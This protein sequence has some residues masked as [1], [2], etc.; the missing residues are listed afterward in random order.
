MDEGLRIFREELPRIDL[1]VTAS[2]MMGA[3]LEAWGV[4]REKIVRIPLGVDLHRFRPPTPELRA[5]ARRRLGIPDERTCVGSFQKDGVGWGEGTEPKLIKGPDVFVSVCNRL[6]SYCP[7]FVLLTGPARGYVKAKLEASGIPYRHD[8][9][10]DPADLPRYYH[11]LDM[12]L[13]TAREEG[14]PLALPEAMAAGTPII[15]TRVGMAPDMIVTGENG[16]LV[17]VEDVDALAESARRL[18]DDPPMRERLARSALATVQDYNRF[19]LARSLCERV[20]KRWLPVQHSVAVPL[21]E[22]M[23]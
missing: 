21:E 18:V 3:R 8:N 5:V 4:P 13:V 1:V 12:Y 2:R 22:D 11:A 19:S 17:D 23:R 6:Q 14:G 16:I 15:S 20:Y 9:L 7:L 10:A